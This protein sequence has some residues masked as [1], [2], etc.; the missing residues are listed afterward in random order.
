MTDCRA[1]GETSGV[2]SNGISVQLR[3]DRAIQALLDEEIG[4][5][6]SAGIGQ[7]G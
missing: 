7:R 5:E 3:I 1:N 4:G 2:T 6:A